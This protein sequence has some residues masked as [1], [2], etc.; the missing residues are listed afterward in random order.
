L[1][2]RGE[3]AA[4]ARELATWPDVPTAADLLRRHTLLRAGTL[5]AMGVTDLPAP[6]AG[7]WLA[8]PPRWERLHRELAAAVEAHAARD[9]LSAGMP[10]DAARVALGLPDRAL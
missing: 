5:A 8:D 2:R 10:V 3:A 6:V 4:A 1:T 7:D 9:P